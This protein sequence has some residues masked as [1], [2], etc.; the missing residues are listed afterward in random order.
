M[1]KKKKGACKYYNE[2]A[3]NNNKA[4]DEMSRQEKIGYAYASETEEM[5]YTHLLIR[6]NE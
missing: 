1:K 2:N 5:A 4:A 6:Y 3:A